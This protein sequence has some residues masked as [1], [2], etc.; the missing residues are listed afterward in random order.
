MRRGRK[1]EY[2]FDKLKII[3]NEYALE[4]IDIKITVPGLVKE[5]G[6]SKNTWY[7]CQEILDYIEHLNS[8]P[9]TIAIAE[10]NFPTVTE[11]FDK[12]KGDEKK[13]K[14]VFVQLL[15]IIETL[16]NQFDGYKKANENITPEE[17]VALKEAIKA[18]NLIIAKQNDKINALTMKDDR[19]INIGD[20]LDKMKTKKFSEQ[21][22]YLL[23]D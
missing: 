21:F 15:D 3:V 8:N 1:T 22:G 6:V 19:L 9:D 20:N 7:R 5:T 23:D 17:I 4:H 2:S 11:L 18:K 14:A 13:T 12:C 10:G 16:T